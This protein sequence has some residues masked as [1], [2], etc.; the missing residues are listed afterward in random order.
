MIINILSSFMILV[1]C[2]CRLSLESWRAHHPELW[3]HSFLAVSSL[4]VGLSNLRG[5]TQN[6]FEIGLNA[7]M[8]AYFMVQS[9]RMRGG[10]NFVKYW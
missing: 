9:W 7:A 5:D 10:R 8:A 2:V 1:H 6:P 4:C 3:I